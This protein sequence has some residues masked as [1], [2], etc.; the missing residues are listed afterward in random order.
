MLSRK[1]ALFTLR[2]T[3][4][5]AVVLFMVAEECPIAKFATQLH[6]E[7]SQMRGHV[8]GEVI[9]LSPTFCSF[10]IGVSLI[11]LVVAPAI[12]SRPRTP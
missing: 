1:A 6:P 12:W 10:V 8:V 9:N 11:G 7:F 3:F 2:M 4:L 5:E